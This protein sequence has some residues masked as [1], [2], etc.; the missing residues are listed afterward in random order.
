ML[1]ILSWAIVIRAL[2][3]WFPQAYNNPITKFIYEVTEPIL[4]P[5]RLIRIGGMI[6]FSPIFAIIA[7]NIVSGI[8][9]PMLYGFLIRL[10]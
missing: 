1:M 2:L 4:K 6:D 8:I 3:S 9:L 10:L 7:I 5:F